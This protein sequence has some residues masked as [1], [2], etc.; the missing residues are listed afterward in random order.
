T[1]PPRPSSS[2]GSRT[3]ASRRSWR[4]FP[5]R[6]PRWR[7]TRSRH[8]PSPS[9]T[10]TSGS[11]VS[12][13]S[14]P[15]GVSTVV[16]FVIDPSGK[17][18]Y[19]VEEQEQLLARWKEEFPQLPIIAVETKCDL[20]RRPTDRLQVS[21]TTGEGLESLEAQ[22]RELVRPRGELPP[23]Q[24]A[25]VEETTVEPDYEERPSRRPSSRRGGSRDRAS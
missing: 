11:T 25:V 2:P 21:A 1:R 4:A 7:T 14:I 17:C 23:M 10:P 24:E 20:V 16:V 5:R 9:A 22:V 6:T 18:G 8:S 19:P 12:R 3:S 15:R 13:C